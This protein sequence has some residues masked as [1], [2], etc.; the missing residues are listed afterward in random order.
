MGVKNVTDYEKLY[1]RD[2]KVCGDPFPEFVEFFE[3]YCGSQ[4]SVLD[5]G[6]GQGRDSLMVA[7]KGHRVVGVDQSRTGVEQMCQAASREG[8]P[9]IGVVADL[10]GYLPDKLFN[11]VILDRT[12]HMFRGLA[13]RMR[14]LA[15]SADCVAPNGHLLIADEP[16]NKQH[17]DAFF[18]SRG[19]SWHVHVSNKNFT[20]AQR[21]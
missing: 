8:I 15:M 21:Q 14:V 18:T 7:R 16:S 12:L 11:V 19:D 3:R 20:F 17:F 2:P 1:Q 9:V 6:C 5:L 10:L 13:D 4:L